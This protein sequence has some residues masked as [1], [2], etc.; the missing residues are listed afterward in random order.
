MLNATKLLTHEL[1]RWSSR[2]AGE[3]YQAVRTTILLE[4][5]FGRSYNLPESGAVFRLKRVKVKFPWLREQARQSLERNL[6]FRAVYVLSHL[7]GN[8]TDR[9]A[10]G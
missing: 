2:K 8:A 6:C 7:F 10:V 5:E 3:L 1:L 9:P 4:P